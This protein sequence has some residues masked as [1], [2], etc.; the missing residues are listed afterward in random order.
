MGM[1]WLCP[2]CGSHTTIN[3]DRMSR[4]IHWIE[5]PSRMGK[6]ALH[7][8]AIACPNDK[9]QGLLVGASMSTFRYDGTTRRLDKVHTEWPLIPQGAAK[10][11]P[12]YVPAPI[13][14]DYREACLIRHLSPKASATL[15]RRCLQGMIRDFWKISKSRLVDEIDA[16][17]DRIDP[18]TWQ[19]ID[20]V[21]K[22]GNIGAHMEKDI[23]LV[24]EV[25]PDEAGLLIELI[26]TLIEDWYVDR[27][28][29]AQRTKRIVA[30]AESKKPSKPTTPADAATVT[31][32]AKPASKGGGSDT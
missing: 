20:A 4:G 27:H 23:N 1:N 7:S 29:R 3:D 11:L 12:D 21:R 25:D 16:L 8:L 18:T 15:A 6:Q 31:P 32:A 10:P 2:F 22:I 24:L 13:V 28:N 17:S 9:C 19:A 26:E 5:L 30:A 14:E